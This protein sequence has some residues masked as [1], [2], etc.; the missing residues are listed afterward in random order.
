[1]PHIEEKKP[2]FLPLCLG[3]VGVVYGDVG[4]S[5]LYAIKEIFT[6]TYGLVPNSLNI[7]GAI[8][9][10]FW[11][12]ILV[13]CIKYVIFVLR[14]DNRGEGGI[15]A[16]MALALRGRHRVRHRTVITTL[17]LIGAALF[18][19]DGVITPAISVLSAVEG[20]EIAAPNLHAYVI[21]IAIGV[22]VGLFLFQK[23]GTDQVGKLFGPIM[24]V[25]FISLALLGIQSIARSPEIIQTINPMHGIRFF[26][27]HRW[28][29]FLALG[30]VVLAVTGTEALYADMGH[31][32]RSPIRAS[33]LFFVMPALV[34]NY[35]GQGA[36]LLRQPEAVSNPFYL[37]APE[38]ALYPLIILSTL[39]TVIASQA[40]ISGAF[41]ITRQ[42]VQLEY[43]PRQQFV[44]TSDSQ[45]GQ[46][47][48]PAVNKFLLIAVVI[49]VLTFQT[50]T[51]LAAAYGFAVTGT[52]AITSCLIFVV[53][54]DAWKWPFGWA[55]CFLALILIL[56]LSFFASTAMKIVDGGWLPMM[57][58]AILFLLMSTWKKGRQVLIRHLQKS[59]VSLTGFLEQIADNPLHRVPGTAIYLYGRHLSLPFTLLKNVEYNKVLHDRVVLVTVSIQDIPYVLAKERL[60]VEN[61]GQNFF[62]ITIKF[63]F[64]QSPNIP[65]ALGLV[66]QFGLSLDLGEAIFYLGRETLIPSVDPAMNAWQE[67]LFIFM[68]RNASNPISFFAIPTDRALE[69]GTLIEI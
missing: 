51:N 52:M 17:G 30:A 13:V 21:P 7:F 40:V 68:F 20:L 6:E 32:G 43:I 11:A 64:K 53:A 10:I 12:L 8:S 69:L 63:G 50:S 41:S 16:L 29:G 4:T 49:L 33:W 42:A 36:L 2:G 66:R 65:H 62:R 67:R 45:M 38:W 9:L 14:A 22:L 28:G 58:G 19:G 25:W 59:A 1:M 47:Y 3:A 46:I 37:L 39:A 5:P 18:Y 55:C 35:L 23:A 34:L 61:L 44:H 31:F 27:E 15:M 54:L 57:I 48:A 60:E 24:V 56:D 26:A